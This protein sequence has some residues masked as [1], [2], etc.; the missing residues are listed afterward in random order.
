MIDSVTLWMLIIVTVEKEMFAAEAINIMNSKGTNKKGI[1]VVFVTDS[2]LN[3][4]TCKENVV[5][6]HS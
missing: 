3:E 5:G 6:S 2:K 1:T 4:E